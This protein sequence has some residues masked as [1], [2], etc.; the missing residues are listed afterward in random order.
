M[1]SL[2]D[3]CGPNNAPSD[4][5]ERSAGLSKAM[6]A[7]LAAVDAWRVGQSLCDRQAAN[8]ALLVRLFIVHRARTM[9][10]ANA[11]LVA[12]GARPVRRRAAA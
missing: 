11:A 7:A 6:D 4:G 9:K 5:A 12:L 8:D 2:A 1:K 3:I 10:E